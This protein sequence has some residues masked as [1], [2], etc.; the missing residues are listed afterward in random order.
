MPKIEDPDFVDL[1]ASEFE[2]RGLKLSNRLFDVVF[3]HVLKLGTEDGKLIF[4]GTNKQALAE[5]Q[6]VLTKYFDSGFYSD[7]APD[8]AAELVNIENS[9]EYFQQVENGVQFTQA[10][11]NTE[12]NPIKKLFAENAIGAF[13]RTSFDQKIGNPIMNSLLESVRFGYTLEQTKKALER[14]TD[15]FGSYAG[16]IVRDTTFGYD[17][18]INA[19][20]AE[21]IG[22]NAYK[23]IGT[24]IKDS[25]PQCRKWKKKR[26]LPFSELPKEIAW[27]N[28]IKNS[29]MIPGT[30]K[31]NFAVRRGGHNCRHRAIPIILEPEN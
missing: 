29:G 6:N 24:I 19:V 27:A 12:I 26:V 7:F 16:Q 2:S 28:S 8:L 3:A 14:R 5:L 10:F 23:Y 1:I 13:N 11:K 22:A 18:Q 20:Y 15:A 17:G 4:D 9:G 21:K 31:E 30:N 25:R